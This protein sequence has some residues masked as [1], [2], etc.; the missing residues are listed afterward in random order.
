MLALLRLMNLFLNNC[1]GTLYFEVDF[2]RLK[3]Q[4]ALYEPK[5]EEEHVKV[6]ITLAWN[7]PQDPSFNFADEP[8]RLKRTHSFHENE[9]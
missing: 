9:K 5:T 3:P 7:A 6:I 8:T 4:K 1:H 2:S